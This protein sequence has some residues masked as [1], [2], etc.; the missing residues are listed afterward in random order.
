MEYGREAEQS[1]RDLRRDLGVSMIKSPVPLSKNT[2]EQ[3]S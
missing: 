2:G 3:A 1:F